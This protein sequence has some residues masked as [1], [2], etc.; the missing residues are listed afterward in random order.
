MHGLFCWVVVHSWSKEFE[1]QCWQL[2]TRKKYKIFRLIYNVKKKKNRF[3]M[4][5]RYFFLYICRAKKNVYGT[6]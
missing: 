1:Q 2:K 3:Y 6:V 5:C 4:L